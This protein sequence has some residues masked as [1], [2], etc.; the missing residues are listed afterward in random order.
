MDKEKESLVAVYTSNDPVE[1]AMIEAALTDAEIEFAVHDHEVMDYLQSTEL[2]SRSQILVLE[3][4][5]E[6]AREIV[7]EVRKTENT[8]IAG[9]TK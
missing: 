1:G 4:D 2:D 7:A 3:E 9:D 8:D 6:R 5:F